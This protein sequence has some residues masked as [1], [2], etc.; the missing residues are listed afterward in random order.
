M[1]S[2]GFLCS[3]LSP[4]PVILLLYTGSFLPSTK[5]GMCRTCCCCWSSCFDFVGDGLRGG[6]IGA[7]AAAAAASCSFCDSGTLGADADVERL[8][9]AD[10]GTLSPGLT[11]L[12]CW[13]GVPDSGMVA[14]EDGLRFS[15]W[16][17]TLGGSEAERSS[18]GDASAACAAVCLGLPLA[19]S[20]VV[21]LGDPPTGC[22]LWPMCTTLMGM[23]SVGGSLCLLG[24]APGG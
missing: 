12:A 15:L 11:A 4:P 5:I 19:G 22:F 24:A 3:A 18:L 23:D 13:G 8:W 1:K 17:N 10:S 2:E 7:A 16:L 9:C 14:A 20:C 6:G 21:F